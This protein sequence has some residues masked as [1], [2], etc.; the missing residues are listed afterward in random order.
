MLHQPRRYEDRRQFRPIRDLELGQPAVT[1]GSVVAMGVKWF[2]QRQKSIFEIV[3]DD[4]SPQ[5]VRKGNN[6]SE[7][8]KGV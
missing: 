8:F 7:Q 2:R 1:R 4:S 3:L 6:T 5:P